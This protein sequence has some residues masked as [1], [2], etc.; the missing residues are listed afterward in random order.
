[1]TYP[2]AQKKVP[3]LWMTPDIPPGNWCMEDALTMNA[4]ANKLG[5]TMAKLSPA[6]HISKENSPKNV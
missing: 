4:E 2:S 5:S 6:M 3:Q 1:M